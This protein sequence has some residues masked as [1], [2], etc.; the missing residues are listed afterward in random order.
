MSV[1]PRGRW[2]EAKYD[3]STDSLKC[4]PHAPGHYRIWHAGD[5]A[6]RYSGLAGTSLRTEVLAK[7]SDVST[8]SGKPKL[9]PGCKVQYKPYPSDTTR[10]QAQDYEDKDIKKCVNRG[11]GQDNSKNKDGKK[12][13]QNLLLF[14]SLFKCRVFDLY[15]HHICNM[16]GPCF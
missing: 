8:E 3:G 12:N 14:V 4:L 11:G 13:R 7:K 2:N 9:L 16:T 15:C 5:T 10:K 6:A 1:M